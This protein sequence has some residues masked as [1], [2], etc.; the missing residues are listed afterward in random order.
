M[1]WIKLNP[2]EPAFGER[3]LWMNDKNEW[4]DGALEEIKHTTKGK[5]YHVSHDTEGGLFDDAVYFM[6]IELPKD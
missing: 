2:K 4:W 1:K 3:C 5:V 6:K